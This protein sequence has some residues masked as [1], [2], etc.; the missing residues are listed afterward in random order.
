MKIKM[1]VIYGEDLCESLKETFG[2]ETDEELMVV[3]R[4]TMKAAMMKDAIDPRD[5][6]ITCESCD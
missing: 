3:M 1:T 6:S 5:L 4:A 2:C